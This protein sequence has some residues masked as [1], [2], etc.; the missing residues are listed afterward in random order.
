M[1]TS[2]IYGRLLVFALAW[3]S[4]AALAA[5][6]GGGPGGYGGGPGQGG[7]GGGIGGGT[8]NQE[9]P[10][11]P[12]VDKPEAAAKKAYVAG[13][14]SLA[15]AKNYE[16]EA[17]RAANEDKKNAA[18]EKKND[19]YGRALDEFTEALGND[20]EMYDAW[21]NV[22]FIH[23]RLGAYAESV[24]DYNHALALKPDLRDATLHRAEAYMAID[25]LDD[26]KIAYMELFT[27]D[28]QLADQLMVA[29]Q[30][31]T[32]DHRAN[33]NGMR[34]SDID[35]FGTWVQERDGIAKQTASLPH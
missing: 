17:A 5:G 13:M 23:L 21:N 9:I 25:R 6:Y 28:S 29:M 4:A 30:S 10:T 2:L 12:H 14:K 18:L 33:P 22:G 35:A 27:H 15:K 7:P 34:A 31:W 8:G 19:A 11:T 20:G 3:T 26:A 1:R 24:D 16:S 32:T